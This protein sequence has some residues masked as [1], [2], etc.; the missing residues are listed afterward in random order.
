MIL[1]HIIISIIVVACLGYATFRFKKAWSAAQ[2]CHD[3]KCAGCPFYK[4]CENNKKKVSEKFG[5]TK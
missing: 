2:K 4:K 1:Q 5:G 3:Y